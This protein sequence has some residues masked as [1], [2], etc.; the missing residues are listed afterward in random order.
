MART[1][2]T[3]NRP[4]IEEPT[5]LP[6]FRSEFE[7]EDYFADLRAQQDAI[8]AAWDKVPVGTKLRV[9]TARGINSRRRAGVDFSQRPITVEVVDDTETNVAKRIE[10][11]EAVVTPV[12]GKA[13]IDDDGLLVLRAGGLGGG[14]ETAAFADRQLREMADDKA[15][16]ERALSEERS[17]RRELEEELAALRAVKSATSTTV[18]PATKPENETPKSED[19]G[20]KG[21]DSDKPTAKD[22]T[23]RGAPGAKS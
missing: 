21:E 18:T 13:I 1:M 11:G 17:K 8:D 5:R 2:T 19:F 6:R 15:A 10:S 20:G 22:A 4:R 7:R 16:T 23:R 9:S 12:G 3:T 14:D